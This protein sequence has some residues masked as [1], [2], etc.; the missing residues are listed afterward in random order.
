MPAGNGRTGGGCG[1]AVRLRETLLLPAVIHQTG[2]DGLY[3]FCQACIHALDGD[4]L[5]AYLWTD[6]ALQDAG[7]ALAEMR[8]VRGRFTHVYDN[9]CFA[10]VGLSAQVLEGVRSWLRIRGDGAMLYD[11]EKQYLIPPEENRVMLQTHR[12]A[13]LS[14]DEL[15]RR[16]RGEIELKEVF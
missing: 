14:D 10:G 8:Q 13:Q 3:A 9:D 5:Q 7:R 16:L 4:L 12:T 11:W 6:R 1:A 2:C 15:C